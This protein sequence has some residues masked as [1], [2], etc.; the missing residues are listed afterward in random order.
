MNPEIIIVLAQSVGLLGAL[1][2]LI[3]QQRFF[4]S[5]IQLL[6]DKAKSHSFESYKRA[7][8]PLPRMPVPAAPPEDLRTLQEFRIM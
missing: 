4:L 5:Q 1:A 8:N 2:A 3:L 6:V 7:E